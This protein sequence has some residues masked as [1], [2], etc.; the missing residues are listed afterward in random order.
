MNNPSEKGHRTR[1]ADPASYSQHCTCGLP[2][3]SV[4]VEL[5]IG[6]DAAYRV[7]NDLKAAFPGGSVLLLDDAN[8]HKAAG[9]DDFVQIQGA[10]RR[11]TPA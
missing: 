3:P 10:G 5:Y 11:A 9:E 8:T 4:D 2:H 1:V 7:S 6:D